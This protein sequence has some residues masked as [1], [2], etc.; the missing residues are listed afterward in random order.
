MGKRWSGDFYVGRGVTQVG[1]VAERAEFQ[2]FGRYGRWL[3]LASRLAT[4]PGNM[5]VGW[6]GS[7]T[8]SQFHSAKENAPVGSGIP[9]TRGNGDA[10]VI[11]TAALPGRDTGFNTGDARQALVDR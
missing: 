3:L 10:S 2:D 8:L 11:E 4:W 9:A 5:D 6:F 1:F 7:L